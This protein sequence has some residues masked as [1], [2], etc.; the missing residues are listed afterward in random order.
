MVWQYLPL[1]KQQQKT[2]LPLAKHFFFFCVVLEPTPYNL[3][4][5][6]YAFH[7]KTNSAEVVSSFLKTVRGF[8]MFM[9][10]MRVYDGFPGSWGICLVAS[11]RSRSLCEGH[12]LTSFKN[13]MGIRS[14]GLCLWKVLYLYSQE[15]RGERTKGRKRLFLKLSIPWND[16][17]TALNGSLKVE[18]TVRRDYTMNSIS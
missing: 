3:N 8:Y 13:K 11:L 10:M 16:L 4:L 12:P 2:T 18:S 7:L 6:N 17:R 9:T 15:P 1:E 5:E 14:W